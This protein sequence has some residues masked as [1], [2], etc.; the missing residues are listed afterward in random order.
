MEPF[1][2]HAR[3]PTLIVCGVSLADDSPPLHLQQSVCFSV[4]YSVCDQLI[5]LSFP[6]VVEHVSRR[7]PTHRTT[8][9]TPVL[10]GLNP[11]AR[12]Q[13]LPCSV[14]ACHR[15]CWRPGCLGRITSVEEKHTAWMNFSQ[16]AAGVTTATPGKD[17]PTP[18]KPAR[19]AWPTVRTLTYKLLSISFAPNPPVTIQKCTETS[20]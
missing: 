5:Y 17:P 4:I 1:P 12:S 9:V 18:P 13:R 8:R 16:P 15:M 3:T 10:I 2:L 6:S 14:V 19:P 11:T 20:R 7:R